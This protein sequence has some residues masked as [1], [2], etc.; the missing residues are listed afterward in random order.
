MKPYLF[1]DV[2]EVLNVQVH[3]YRE[4]AVHVASRD[5]A[6]T[7]YTGRFRGDIVTFK[8]CLP[9]A[10]AAW[11]AELSTHFE[12]AWATTW[13]HLANTHIAPLLGLDDLAV[14]AFSTLDIPD[15]YGDDSARWKWDGLTRF[16]GDRPFVFLDDGAENLAR[17]YPLVGDADRAALWIERG[18]TRDHVDAVIAWAQY[19]GG[20]AESEEG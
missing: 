1:L 9:S 16:A 18:L 6:R 7:P 19:R 8:V 15:R 2:D 12:L 13:E 10:Y 4:Y 20:T 11:L 17:E 14:V 3:P 5:I